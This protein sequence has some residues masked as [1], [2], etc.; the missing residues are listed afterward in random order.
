MTSPY[1]V[2]WFRCS[3]DPAHGYQEEWRSTRIGAS[4]SAESL[5]SAGGAFHIYRT[6]R[7]AARQ[8]PL[9]GSSQELVLLA[10]VDRSAIDQGAHKVRNS[11][12]VAARIED[13]GC[14]SLSRVI[15]RQVARHGQGPGSNCDELLHDV[16]RQPEAGAHCRILRPG[17]HRV[18]DR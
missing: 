5:R 13:R 12:D 11:V 17:S 14:F 3:P 2:K 7:A 1:L 6:L 8:A 4:L 18:L 15:A 10:G 16:P 9:A